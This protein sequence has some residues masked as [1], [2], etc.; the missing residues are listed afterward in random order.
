[1]S[2]SKL[3]IGKQY[4]LK[5]DCDLTRKYCGLPPAMKKLQGTVVTI[6]D[7]NGKS[8]RIKENPSFVWYMD[9]LISVPE[10]FEQKPVLFDI[11]LLSL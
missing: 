11:D 5:K 3:K 7:I 1:M 9:D 6:C 2:E 10:S 4:L 8:V